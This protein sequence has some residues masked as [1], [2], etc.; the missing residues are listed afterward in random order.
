MWSM[1]PRSGSL[2]ASLAI[3]SRAQ[4]ELVCCLLLLLLLLL[5][6][7]L[8]Y[9]EF[10]FVLFCCCCCYYFCNSLLILGGPGMGGISLLLLEKEM[11]GI[12]IRKM[13]TQFD[14]CHNTTFITLEDVRVPKK[15]LIGEENQ[16]KN[17]FSLLLLLLL[18]IV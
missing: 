9:F 4:S 18:V 8:F 15:N 7:S 13:E 17:F 12:S 16:G 5:L 2:E 6:F 14:N 3:S 1:A 10:S 11:A